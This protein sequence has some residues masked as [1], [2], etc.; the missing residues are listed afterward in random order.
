MPASESPSVIEGGLVVDDRGQLTFANDFNF[1][2]VKRFY[3]V[4]NFSTDVIR[5]WHGH[6][7]EAKFVFVT[8]GSAIVAAVEMDD[9]R[10][11]KK[12]NQVQRWVLSARKP[13][14][15]YIPAGY[16]NGFRPLESGTKVIF[17]TTS[18]MEE[19]KGDDYRFPADYWG[20]KVWQVEN[21]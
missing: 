21:R 8:Q 14:I 7:K 10:A 3:M 20:E 11:P 6:K 16:A 17:F 9:E 12:S 18:T 13:M 15:V 5:A 1:K 2:G 19:T 4:E